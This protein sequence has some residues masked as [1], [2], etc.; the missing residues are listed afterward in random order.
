MTVKNSKFHSVS[1]DIPK[2]LTQLDQIVIISQI[3][4]SVPRQYI[5]EHAG[6]IRFVV[7]DRGDVYDNFQNHV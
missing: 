2:R 3:K 1:G 6:T 4:K 5:K 7:E